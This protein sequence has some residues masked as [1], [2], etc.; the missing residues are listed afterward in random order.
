LT[1]TCSHGTLQAG[2]TFRDIG[3]VVVGSSVATE[4]LLVNNNDCALN[5]ELSVRQIVE[6]NSTDTPKF[7]PR[8][9]EIEDPN[10]CLEARARKLIRLK[11][12]PTRVVNYQFTIEYRII[13]PNEDL[14]RS[15]QSEILCNL[16]ANGVYPKLAISDIKALGASSNLSKDYLWKLF[17]LDTLNSSMNCEPNSDELMYSIATRQDAHRRMP[18]TPKVVVD[19]NFN[20]APINSPDTEIVLFVKNTGVVSADWALLFPKDLQIELEYWSQNGNFTEEELL[21]VY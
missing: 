8:V 2:E 9:L 1:G 12:R 4:L 6:K 7:E 14:N 11:L 15:Q 18:N 20:A 5:F 16:T 10:G 21:E 3:N 17:S 13:Y 19:F